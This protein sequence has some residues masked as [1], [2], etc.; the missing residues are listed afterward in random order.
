MTKQL[1]STLFAF[2]TIITLVAATGPRIQFAEPIHDFGSLEYGTVVTNFFV[3]TNTG[4][5]SLQLSE[6]ISS[7][8]CAAA[9]NW[10]RRVEPGKTGAIPV[11]FSASGIGEYIMKPIRIVCNDSVESN[12]VVYVQA[13]IYK[14]IDAVPSVALFRFGPDFQTNETTTIQLFSNL[15]E[16]VTLSDPVCTNS[17]FKAS[18]K[19]IKP[20]K[21]FELSVSVFPPLGPGS[22]SSPITMK[23]SSDKMPEVKVT[24][25]AMVQPDMTLIPP[26]L[27]L[28][29]TPLT[30]T[31]QLKVT[32]QNNGTNS[33]RLSEPTI[34]AARAQVQ[35][36]EVQPGR[37]FE[38]TMT[39][40]QGFRGKPGQAYF[41]RL[42][43]NSIQSPVVKILVL[44]PMEDSDTA[45]QR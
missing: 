13:Q 31:E 12:A 4:D 17:S 15:S 33:L 16:P 32:I 30:N 8:G 21:E 3:F 37:L 7:C 40:P 41:A 39:F 14:P 2:S 29:V 11:I 38:L 23:S 45:P 27:V 24:A 34:D 19:T 44:E 25:Y 5:Q 6:V 42:K 36:R 35:L 26:R 10:D 22:W 43:S 1:L 9:Q 20:G 18:L 28:P